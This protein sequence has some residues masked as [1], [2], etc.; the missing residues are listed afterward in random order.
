MALRARCAGT[1]QGE[2]LK[3]LKARFAYGEG[4]INRFGMIRGYVGRFRLNVNGIPLFL[5]EEQKLFLDKKR[6]G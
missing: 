5:S 4:R 1:I 3:R 2:R 6:I